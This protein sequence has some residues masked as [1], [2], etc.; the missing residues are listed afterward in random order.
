[1]DFMRKFLVD[2]DIEVS[3]FNKPRDFLHRHYWILR[4]LSFVIAMI[5]L[6]VF[7]QISH[8]EA[9][10]IPKNLQHTAMLPMVHFIITFH[11]VVTKGRKYSDWLVKFADLNMSPTL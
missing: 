7:E 4:I 10:E 6:I 9:I 8:Q 5:S 3:W 11:I 1:M 2:P